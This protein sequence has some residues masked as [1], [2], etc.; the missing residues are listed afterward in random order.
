[1]NLNQAFGHLRTLL[2]GSEWGAPQREELWQ[3]VQHIERAHLKQ[4]AS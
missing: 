1:M 4:Y 2:N 3:L